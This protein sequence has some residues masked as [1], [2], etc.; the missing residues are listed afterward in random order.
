[1]LRRSLSFGVAAILAVAGCSQSGDT[2]VDETVTTATVAATRVE[3]TAMATVP[4]TTVASA[5]TS[6]N[7]AVELPAPG[8]PWDLLYLSS[9]Y[10]WGV[11]D[12]YGEHASEALGVPINVHDHSIGGLTAVEALAHIQDDRYPPLADLV[13]DAE[14][15]VVYGSP[16]H[17]GVKSDLET[18]ASNSVSERT[19]PGA[20][21]T[22][23]WQPYR[24][25]LDE[26]YTEIWRLREGAPTVL[27]AVDF[28]N[29]RISS[30]RTAGIES[31]CTAASESQSAAIRSAAEANGAIM[32]SLYDL[33]NGPDH[34]DDPREKG[35]IGT[36][37]YHANDAGAAAIADALAAAGFEPT[38]QP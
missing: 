8:E 3:T 25:V 28:I 14:I 29:G 35:W 12:P 20:Y 32:V 34:Q 2:G 16:R 11:A 22:D 33:F 18:C 7:P 21:T 10:G 26:I 6:T 24:D 38:T 17:S 1:M 19:P 30:W 9:S 5:I 31:E 4:T 37:G 27:R 15:I 36:D 13:R 23:D